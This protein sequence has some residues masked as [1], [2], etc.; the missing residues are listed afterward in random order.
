MTG[1]FGPA[2][3]LSYER[4]SVPS[5]SSYTAPGHADP[6]PEGEPPAPSAARPHLP[7]HGPLI[8]SG[9]GGAE[10]VFGAA[11]PPAGCPQRWARPA[12][13]LLG[14]ERE[15]PRPAAEIGEG[16]SRSAQVRVDRR[17][18]SCCR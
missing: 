6:G 2:P 15:P 11:P 7:E 8:G 16:P 9:E 3:P 18:V 10:G 17:A 1:G 12:G 4:G 14:A 5:R 13:I